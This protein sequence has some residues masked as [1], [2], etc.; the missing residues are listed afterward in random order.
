MR[1]ADWCFV[2]TELRLRIPL[3]SFLFHTRNCSFISHQVEAELPLNTV[4]YYM[5]FSMSIILHSR[6]S[7]LRIMLSFETKDTREGERTKGA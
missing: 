5:R 4:G 6:A 1:E 3:L 7:G 2:Q